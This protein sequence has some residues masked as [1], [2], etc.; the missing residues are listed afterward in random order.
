M[1]GNKIK[2]AHPGTDSYF[3]ACK[4][5]GIRGALGNFHVFSTGTW[6]VILDYS[7]NRMWMKLWSTHVLFSSSPLFHTFSK[8]KLN[9]R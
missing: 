5:I 2:K 1:S 3:Y 4:C 7:Q 6:I 9:L 8:E